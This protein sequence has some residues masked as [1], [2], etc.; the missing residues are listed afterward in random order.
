M[1]IIGGRPSQTSI[2]A[3]SS[4]KSRSQDCLLTEQF[5]Y[6]DNVNRDLDN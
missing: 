2:A 3:L 5:E 6:Y 1:Y 4:H